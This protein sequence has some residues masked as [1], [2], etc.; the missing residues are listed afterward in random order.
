MDMMINTEVAGS[1]HG[2]SVTVQQL[3][4]SCSRTCAHVTKQ[5]KFVQQ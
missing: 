3:S 5:Y 1:T 4:A 2:R